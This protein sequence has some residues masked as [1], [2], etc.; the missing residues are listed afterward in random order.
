MSDL[1]GNVEELRKSLPHVDLETGLKNRGIN[2]KASFCVYFS[3]TWEK[4][5]TSLFIFLQVV[6]RDPIAGLGDLPKEYC[7][8]GKPKAVHQNRK[9][10]FFFVYNHPLLPKV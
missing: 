5:F 1:N 10:E 9:S 3:L 4:N 7:E 6:K 8:L 2:F